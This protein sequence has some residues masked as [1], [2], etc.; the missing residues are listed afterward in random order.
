MEE[1]ILDNLRRG[2]SVA[3]IGPSD[4]GKSYFIKNR[5]IP[6][7]EAEGYDV[8]YF[9][10]GNSIKEKPCDIV[11]FDEA[12][13]LLDQKIIEEKSGELYSVEYLEKVRSWGE[14]YELFKQP[15]IFVISRGGEDV[16]YLVQNLKDV[17]SK[18]VK[19]IL[20]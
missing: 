5:L 16:N 18:T 6:F 12:E 9:A 2:T 10:D 7:L 8:A 17:G 20:L 19:S 13:T 15:A 1:E 11:I 3:I 14:A 4:S